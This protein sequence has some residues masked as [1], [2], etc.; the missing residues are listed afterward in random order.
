MATHSR[1][2]ARRI[3]WTEE[4]DGLQSMGT[5]KSWTLTGGTYA[6]IHV[7]SLFLVTIA[8]ILNLFL[9]AGSAKFFACSISH[10]LCNMLERGYC[11]I[12]ITA[13]NYQIIGLQSPSF[14]YSRS[15]L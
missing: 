15:M 12:N 13:I 14:S 6:C 11:G 8:N 4:P 1:I 9:C 2:L 3:P 5:A 10:K 7:L